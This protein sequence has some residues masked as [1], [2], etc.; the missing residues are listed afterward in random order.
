MRLSSGAEALAA[1]VVAQGEVHGFG[2]S[3]ELEPA[4]ARDMAGWDAYARSRGAPLW[5]LLARRVSPRVPL[6]RDDEPALKPDWEAARRA[7]A[8]KR[9]RLLRVDP[10]AW[11]S[12]ELVQTLAAAA[13]E[14]AIPLA[15]LA[16]SAHPWEIAWCAA[17]AGRDDRVIVRREPPAPFVESPDEPG[18]GVP[19]ALEPTFGSIR[20]LDPPA[21]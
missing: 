17:L 9:H 19:W 1:R 18:S 12:L 5:R 14:F 10:F 16:P 4:V 6:A 7:M 20:W 15:L 8:E 3:L 2:F 21:S 11:G 13:A